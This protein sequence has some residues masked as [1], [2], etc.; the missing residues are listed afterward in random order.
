[1]PFDLAFVSR[2]LS[3][4]KPLIIVC[5]LR[6]VRHCP[7]V[8]DVLL[9]EDCDL[10]VACCSHT[11]ANLRCWA[12][13]AT[14]AHVVTLQYLTNQIITSRVVYASNHISGASPINPPSDTPSIAPPIRDAVKAMT[15]RLTC[16]HKPTHL[17]LKTTLA[18]P[19]TTWA[20]QSTLSAAPS[21]T[22]HVVCKSYKTPPP[23]HLYPVCTTHAHHICNNV[24]QPRRC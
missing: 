17:V 9:A 21:P 15:Y 11:L 5:S 6:Y 22:R 14:T 10:D 4:T 19:G 1:M 23:T 13:A 20:A 24:T 7:C 2:M 12:R 3:Q 18:V 16:A 8:Q